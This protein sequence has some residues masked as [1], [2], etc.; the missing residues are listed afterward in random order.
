MRIKGPPFRVEAGTA[1]GSVLRWGCALVAGAGLLALSPASAGTRSREVYRRAVPVELRTGVVAVRAVHGA[2]MDVPVECE[3]QGGGLTCREATRFPTVYAV[4]FE[5]EK[6]ETREDGPR[7]DLVDRGT[8]YLALRFDAAD[9]EAFAEQLRQV[10]AGLSPDA[11]GESFAGLGDDKPPFAS[12]R[13]KSVEP[14]WTCFQDGSRLRATRH[15]RKTMVLPDGSSGVASVST[16]TYSGKEVTGPVCDGA[17]S[18]VE[19]AHPE[20][21]RTTP[22]PHVLRETVVRSRIE[23]ELVLEAYADDLVALP[24][25]ASFTMA[26][27]GAGSGEATSTVREGTFSKAS[28][29]DNHVKRTAVTVPAELPSGAVTRGAWL[30]RWT[31]ETVERRLGPLPGERVLDRDSLIVVLLPT[32]PPVPVDENDR[33]RPTARRDTYPVRFDSEAFLEEVARRLDRQANLDLETL[34]TAI[35]VYPAGL[36]SNGWILVVCRPDG[37]ADYGVP[38]TR[39]RSRVTNAALFC[40]A[41]D[42]RI[43]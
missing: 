9:E 15:S 43:E 32:L 7:I 18:A 24:E 20:E 13:E 39:A 34:E 22:L 19:N 35:A 27:S 6:R 26:P 31:I 14:S 40:A 29:T 36:R 16:D 11:F 28:H 30:S 2:L 4:G 38:S 10:L 33:P 37:T 42:S 3:P 1:S 25:G 12:I 41:A 21:I 17:A 5:L 8:V 23:D